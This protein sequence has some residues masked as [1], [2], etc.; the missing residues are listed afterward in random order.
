MKLVENAP[1]VV[2]R[3]DVSRGGRI[4]V[5][6]FPYREDIVDAVR[7]VPGRRF[8][9]DARG[10]S[11]WHSPYPDWLTTRYEAKARREG[12]STA[13]LTFRRKAA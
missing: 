12:R 5:L 9:W 1:N 6:S 2:L 3:A 11:D 10:A 8:D 13:Y 7:Q 4:V